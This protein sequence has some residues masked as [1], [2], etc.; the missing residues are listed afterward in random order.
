MHEKRRYILFFVN[1]IIDADGLEKM[2]YEAVNK[3]DKT[4]SIRSNLRLIKDLFIQRGNEVLSVMSVN[5]KYK[6]D[7]I[8]ILSLISRF[9]PAI[10]L[11]TLKNSGSLKKIKRYMK[12]YGTISQ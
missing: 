8:F 2:I 10:N 3:L 9:F 11:V 12:Q 6:Y 1:S 4:L 7:V 5:N